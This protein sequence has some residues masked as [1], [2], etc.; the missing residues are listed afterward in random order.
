MGRGLLGARL[1][2]QNSACTVLQ[3][4]ALC[5]LVH[6]STQRH[7]PVDGCAVAA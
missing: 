4:S 7:R 5:V 3:E 6:T 2:L 1:L